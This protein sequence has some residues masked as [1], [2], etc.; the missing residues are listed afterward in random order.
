MH[1]KIIA[2][3]SFRDNL[4]CIECTMK[5][6]ATMRMDGKVL[7]NRVCGM[8]QDLQRTRVVSAHAGHL[9]LGDWIR[10]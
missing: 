2:R 9:V 1:V 10:A 5:R 3:R 6:V 7:Y 4:G 8:L